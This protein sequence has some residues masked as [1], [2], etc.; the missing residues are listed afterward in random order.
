M[1]K[2]YRVA[3]CDDE[4][5]HLEALRQD[6]EDLLAAL[7]YAYHL[8]AYS[9][10]PDLMR[11]IRTVPDAFDLILLDVLL[12]EQDGM[13]VARQLRQE[14]CDTPLVFVTVTADFAPKG[15]EVDAFRYLLKP[16]NRAELE[17]TLLAAYRKTRADE[18]L[19][20]QKGSQVLRIRPRDIAY[21][22]T[23]GR[24]VV[25]HLATG[26]IAL[27][28][29]ISEV[30]QML[31]AATLVRCHKSYIVGIQHIEHI[32]RTEITLSAGARI[33]VGRKYYND[34]RRALMSYLS[35]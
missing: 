7:G 10:G 30:E 15:Y 35:R 24:G 11:A 19:T 23:E 20:F 25:L 9:S 2:I 28:S 5:S 18:R 17:T 13:E 1:N 14:G 34:V 29:K 3:L 8:R 22:D 33:P 4:P 6:T 21:I 32:G 16:I 12:G 26:D 27:P 31:P